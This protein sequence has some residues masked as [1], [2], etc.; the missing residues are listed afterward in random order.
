MIARGDQVGFLR[1][2]RLTG[3]LAHTF[4]DEPV[5]LVIDRDRIVDA[6]PSG[7]LRAEGAVLEGDGRRLVAGLWDHHVHTVQWALNA[8]R[9]PLGTMRSAAE[10]ARAMGDAVALA[11]GRRVGAGMR[12]ALWPD[13]PSLTLLDERT[14][15][16]PT[17]LINADVHSVWLNTAA[18]R[19][20]GFEPIADGMLREEDAFEI[21][22][23]LNA[24]DDLMADAAVHRAGERAAARGVT[25]LVDFDMAWNADAWQR[26]AHAGFA[27]HRVE[28]AF[29]AA[30]LHRAIERGLRT[31]DELASTS[32]LVHVGPLKLITDGS[33][34]TRTAACS[35][36]YDDDPTNFG[37][38]TIEPDRLRELL[39]TATASG[40]EVAVHAI[41]DRAVASALDAFT[42]TQARG[43][44][45]HA[46]L[47]R[48]ADLV[49]F[50]RLGV[51]ASV[52]P[53]HAIDDRDLVGSLWQ[54]QQALSHP[55]GSLIEAGIPVRFGSDAPVAPL[56]P[57]LTIA[58]AVHRTGDDREPWRP[59]E[60]VGIE[61]AL[62]ASSRHGGSDI[63]I[64]GIA[65]LALC[66]IDPLT[67]DRAELSRMPVAATLLGGRLTHLA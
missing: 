17:Y 1:A 20:E 43:T 15:A 31:G 33:L 11:D 42:F 50:A 3:P 19:R 2:V 66:E 63:E 16:E 32:G 7:A 24:A 60:R 61:S 46:Q 57:W 9:V 36:A 67:A 34:G 10:A 41:G 5:D 23:R 37:V 22:R 28:F 4:G 49:R 14:G 13:V 21:S 29:Y 6:A 58:A 55:L 40:I 59:E 65:D 62:R 26:R 64:G 39:T 44:I 18:F 12:D 56:D 53:E 25:G 27:A 30:E 45:E 38:L 8:D 51:I 48:H 35:H 54:H 47:V 52:Q